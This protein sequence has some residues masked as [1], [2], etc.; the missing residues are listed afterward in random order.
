MVSWTR[1]KTSAHRLIKE[2]NLKFNDMYR[3]Y[4]LMINVRMAQQPKRCEKKKKNNY[5]DNIWNVNNVN[6]YNSPS[7]KSRR[8]LSIRVDN[9]PCLFF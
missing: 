3:I 8:N 1:K 5:K 2:F 9:V 4:K 6:N 7:K